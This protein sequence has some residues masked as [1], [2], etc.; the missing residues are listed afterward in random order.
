MA[1]CGELK[2]N[3]E[4]Y[5]KNVWVTPFEKMCV[6]ERDSNWEVLCRRPSQDGFCVVVV[7]V[8]YPF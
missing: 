6:I 7:D 2:P 3:A 4:Y 1:I 8:V 5:I